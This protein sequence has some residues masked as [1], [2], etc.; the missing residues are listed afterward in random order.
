VRP[1][2]DADYGIP[3][4]H[5]EGAARA[6]VVLYVHTEERATLRFETHR[7]PLLPSFLPER[8]TTL[9]D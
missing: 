4:G 2:D 8:I 9:S 7:V 5:A 6:E 1:V 3:I